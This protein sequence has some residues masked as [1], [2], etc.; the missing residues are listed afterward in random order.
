MELSACGSASYPA[1]Y[2]PTI[3]QK[4]SMHPMNVNGSL[5]SII[6]A[7]KRTYYFWTVIPMIV[8]EV[9]VKKHILLILPVFI[10]LQRSYW[11]L[12]ILPNWLWQS[13]VS[14]TLEYNF[15]MDVWWVNTIYLKIPSTYVLRHRSHL[16]MLNFEP[17][18][19]SIQFFM[20]QII[21]ICSSL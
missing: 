15:T 19:A 16:W 18:L 13:V 21:L 11:L 2:M 3:H 14:S 8:G 6:A 4:W 10:C 20:S 9:K 1:P 17:G 12:Y 5:W 7:T